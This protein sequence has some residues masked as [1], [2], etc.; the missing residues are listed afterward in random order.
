MLFDRFLPL[1]PG[2]HQLLY[3]QVF[4][5]DEIESGRE[6]HYKISRPGGEPE[7]D[8]RDFRLA[9]NFM[10]GNEDAGIHGPKKGG[11]RQDSD[12]DAYDDRKDHQG[13]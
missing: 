4:V 2:F 12:K 13:L 3:G 5:E 10:Q 8:R 9:H 1:F 7:T 6:H 11:C